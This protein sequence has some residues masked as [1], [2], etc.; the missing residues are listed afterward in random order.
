[1]NKN[2]TR[3]NGNGVPRGWY[4]FS[5][6]GSAHFYGKR[7]SLVMKKKSNGEWHVWDMERN[8]S[9]VNGKTMVECHEAVLALLE[10]ATTRT[11]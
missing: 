3:T 8:G 7:N 11:T 2:T 1:M 6:S 5:N 4:R 9:I 10:E